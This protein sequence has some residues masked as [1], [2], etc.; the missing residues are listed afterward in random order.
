MFE[1]F[2]DVS[3]DLLRAFEVAA[4][5][6][7]FTAAAL[8]LGT[9]QPA[10]SQQIKRLEE[11][12]ATRLFDRIYRGIELTDA[13]EVLFS[14]VQAGLQSIDSGVI[15]ITEHHQHEVLQVATDFAF[16]AYWLMPRLHRFHKVNPDV[17]VSLVTSERTHS[18]LRADIDVAV[19]FGDGRFKQGESHWL[20]SE[21]VFPVCSP[22]LLA[23]RQT[24]LPT[25]ALRDFPLLHLR[26]ESI[27]NWFDW[28]GVF[29]ALDIPQAPAP[30]QL[31]F[32]NYTLLIQAAI[33]GQ[34]IAIGW[35][36]LVDD[37]LDQ[38]LLCRPIAGAAI[39]GQGYY[40]VLPQRKRR[41]QIVQQF[42]DWLAS[43]QALS[44]VSLT[45]RP[46]P[47]IAV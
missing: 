13:G 38:G 15:A 46:L 20:F 23:G 9:T 8:E 21:E 25:D 10:V 16:A 31:R 42:V 19:L 22:Q 12:L 45:G 26:G 30:G 2:G 4:R 28:A 3:L 35:K 37:L 17:D 39:S 36:H 11:Q 24:P 40:V 32:D 41:V 1:S 47:S 33:G 6:R 27:N 7:S 14:H 5:L 43:E 29:R 34:G 18:M 44:G